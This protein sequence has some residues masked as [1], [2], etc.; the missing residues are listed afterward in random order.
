MSD[1]TTRAGIARIASATIVACGL[2]VPAWAQAQPAAPPPD[3]TGSAGA[4]ISVTNGNSDTVNYNLAFELKHD[5]MTRNVIKAT[6]LYLRGTQEGSLTVNRTSLGLRDEYELSSR[7]F[8]FGQVEYLRDTFK[9]IDY[10]VAPT[11]G[12]GFKIVDTERTQYAVDVGVGA[13]WE[14]NPGLD[15]RTNAVI[16]AGEKLTHQFTPTATFKHAATALWTADD[17]EDGLYT[18]SI[19]LA[20]K[21]T[22]RV[23][24]TID[25]LDTYKNLPPTPETKKNDVALVTAIAASF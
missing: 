7:T 5:P 12:I 8:L 2:A 18:V 15:T 14:K 16:S 21:I 3:W 20:T 6:G 1:F 11:G 25:V 19:G 22:E 9:L 10:L 13:S 24:L 17:F 4:G 23:Q